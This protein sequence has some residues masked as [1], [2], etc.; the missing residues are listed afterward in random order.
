MRL[1]GD[2]VPAGEQLARAVGA[3]VVGQLGLVALQHGV[4]VLDVAVVMYHRLGHG[5]VATGAN[6]P[7]QITNPQHQLGQRHGALVQ[8]NAQQLLW[9]DGFAF[10]PQH[11]LRLAQGFELVQHFAFQALQVL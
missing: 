2:A 1:E 3:I 5:L 7:L 9:R 4:A 8:L 6:V 10:Q 11:T